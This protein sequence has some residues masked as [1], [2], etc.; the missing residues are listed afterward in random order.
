MKKPFRSADPIRRAQPG[1]GQP[2]G[3]LPT[4]KAQVETLRKQVEG[5]E[6]RLDRRLTKGEPA[7]AV[8]ERV[9]L[10]QP[11]SFAF[12]YLQDGVSPSVDA[13]YVVQDG[14]TYEIPIV[15]PPPGV[16]RA[17]Y[18]KVNIYQRV[19]TSS[20]PF[21]LPVAYGDYFS[22]F[23]P[24]QVEVQTRKYLFPDNAGGTFTA[25]PQ[26]VSRRMSFLWNIIDTKSGVQF[27]DEMLP[28]LML[29]PQSPT[30]GPA[31]YGD[32]NIGATGGRFE[33]T[34]PWLFERDA[35]LTF[36]FRPITP[37]IQPTATSGYFPFNYDDR[38]QNNTVRNMA[39]TVRAEVHGTRYVDAQDALRLGARIGDEGDDQ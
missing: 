4:L 17:R 1:A 29:L 28:D 14:I 38:E 3:W 12:D 23:N 21:Q 25:T 6:L 27:A 20:G 35:Q 37:A 8:G 5:I 30:Q 36:L 16:F 11:T 34:T 9:F 13:Q 15:F 7:A 26:Y 24:P 2:I 31:S 10:P 22:A 39:I 32:Q 33:F 19:F 18:F